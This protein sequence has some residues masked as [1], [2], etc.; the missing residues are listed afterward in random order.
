M[1]RSDE[2]FFGREDDPSDAGRAIG[3]YLDFARRARYQAIEGS[4]ATTLTSIGESCPTA[5]PD[6][7]FACNLAR[8]AMRLDGT[9]ELVG[10]ATVRLPV[11]SEGV[12]IGGVVVRRTDGGSGG[13]PTPTAQPGRPQ[14]T[15]SWT[16]APTPTRG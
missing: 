3:T 4:L 15:G 13:R 6:R 2:A 12:G 8:F 16:P 1:A 9:F 7:R 5:E 10:D 11:F 14:P